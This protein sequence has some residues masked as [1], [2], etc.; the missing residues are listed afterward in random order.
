M[1]IK[2][3][4]SLRAALLSCYAVTATLTTSLTTGTLAIGAVSFTL[5]S[6]QKV[7]AADTIRAKNGADGGQIVPDSNTNAAQNGWTLTQT[8]S[9]TFDFTAGWFGGG[10]FTLTAPTLYVQNWKQTG[11]SGSGHYIVNGNLTN[12]T[13]GAVGNIT[14]AH[15]G[16][17][18]NNAIFNGHHKNFSGNF[19]M[20]IT[21]NGIDFVFTNTDASP[22]DAENPSDGKAISGTGAIELGI[23]DASSAF[24][25]NAVARD[26]IFFYSGDVSIS[27]TAINADALS[28]NG[29]ST[30]ANTSSDYKTSRTAGTATNGATYT[31]SSAINVNTLEINDGST[32]R[33]IERSSSAGVVSFTSGSSLR[34][35]TDATLNLTGASTLTENALLQIEAEGSLSLAAGGS[36][37]INGRLNSITALENAGTVNFGTGA[38]IDITGLTAISTVG[39]TLTYQIINGG[40]LTGFRDLTFANIAGIE[41]ITASSHE[42]LFNDDGSLSITQLL[43]GLSYAGSDDIAAPSPFDWNTTDTSFNGGASAFAPGASVTFTGHSSATLTEAI[44]AGIITIATD[45]SL[46][47]SSGGVNTNTLTAEDIH[48]SGSLTLADADVLHEDTNLVFSA[49]GKVVLADGVSIDGANISS[50]ANATIWLESETSATATITGQVTGSTNMRVSGDGTVVLDGTLLAGVSTTTLDAGATLRVNTGSASNDLKSLAGAGT[51]VFAGNDGN[52][53]L[54]LGNF[55]GTVALADGATGLY[56]LANQASGNTYDLIHTG[57][58]AVNVKIYGTGGP[59]HDTNQHHI[60]NLSGNINFSSGSAAGSYARDTIVLSMTQDN[61]WTGTWAVASTEDGGLRVGSEGDRHH[62]LTITH[63]LTTTAPNE[64]WQALEIRNA[65]VAFAEGGS[66]HTNILFANASSELR[67][68]G[69]SQT[70]TNYGTGGENTAEYISASY[71]TNNEATHTYNEFGSIVVDTGADDK[72]ITVSRENLLYRGSVHV[73][74]GTLDIT[75]AT[76]FVNA[77]AMSIAGG[78]LDLSDLAIA[79]DI[80]ASGGTLMGLASYTGQLSVTGDV[81]VQGLYR[82]KATIANSGSLTLLG[83]WDFD[84]T[85]TN[86]GG[87]IL[88][89]DMTLDLSDAV[90]DASS[91]VQLVSDVNLLDASAW[92]DGTGELDMDKVIGLNLEG[93]TYSYEDGVIKYTLTGTTHDVMGGDAANPLTLQLATGA[94][95][96]GDVMEEGDNITFNDRVNLEMTGDSRSILVTLAEGSIVNAIDTEFALTAENLVL[97]AGSS[98]SARDSI[99]AQSVSMATGSEMSIDSVTDTLFSMT[100]TAYLLINDALAAGAV[101]LDNIS[102]EADSELTLKLAAE[103]TTLSLANFVGVVNVTEGVLMNDFLAYSAYNGVSLAA[104]TGLTITSTLATGAVDM[105]NVT[106]EGK[107]TISAIG[108]VTEAGGGSAERTALSLSD[109]FTGELHL[110]S[111]LLDA[112][113]MNLGASS[114]VF[115]SESGFIATV[116]NT[117]SVVDKDVTIS[118]TALVTRAFTDANLQLTG[119]ITGA[120]DTSIR[121]TDN[122]TATL[123]GDMTDFF[124]A[125]SVQQGKLV[126]DTDALTVDRVNVWAGE[127]LEITAGHQLTTVGVSG[128]MDYYTLNIYHSYDLILGDGA[129]FTDN[130]YMRQGTSTVNIMGTDAGGGTYIFKGYIGADAA[131]LQSEFN[132]GANTSVYI[133]GNV[134]SADDGDLPSFMISHWGQNGATGTFNVSGLLDI[135][136]GISNKDG[137]GYMNV[138]SGGTLVLGQGLYALDSG[139]NAGA[140]NLTVKDGG[141]VKLHNQATNTAA[142]VFVVDFAGGS[143]IEALDATTN[144]TNAIRLSGTGA[145]TL[146]ADAAVTQ[147]NVSSVISEVEGSTSTLNISALAGQSFTLSAA[148]T[149]TTGINVTG[150]GSLSVGNAAALGTGALSFDGAI[151]DLN[152]LAVGNAITANGGTLSNFAK[153]TG[154]LSIAG[155]VDTEGT[156]SGSVTVQT[157][158]SLTLNSIFKPVDTIENVGTLTLGADLLLDLSDI[159]LQPGVELQL[160]KAVGFASSANI[161]AFAPGGVVKDG[162]I[163][164]AVSIGRDYT[165]TTDGKLSYTL[166]GN[167]HTSTTATLDWAD[168]AAIGAGTFANEDSVIFST[169]NA[170]A[171]LEGNVLA[172]QVTVET[173][174]SLTVESADPTYTLDMGEIFLQEN[175]NMIVN[176][177]IDFSVTIANLAAGSSLS[178]AELGLAKVTLT[179]D[180]ALILTGAL[181]AGEHTLEKI[182]GGDTSSLSL[183]SAATGGESVSYL[184]QNFTGNLTLTD[185][186]FSSNLAQHESYASVH[187]LATSRYELTDTLGAA[188]AIN[189]LSADAGGLLTLNLSAAADAGTTL[190]LD[191]TFLGDLEVKS[192]VLSAFSTILNV[193]QVTFNDGTS[194]VFNHSTNEHTF[195][196]DVVLADGANVSIRTWG[197][198]TETELRQVD[199]AVIGEANTT[200]TKTDAGLTQLN[201]IENFKGSIVL[202]NGVGGAGKL[203]INSNATALSNITLEASTLLDITGA[204]NIVNTASYSGGSTTQVDAGASLVVTGADA[205]ATEG[206]AASFHLVGTVNVEGIL[207]VNSAISN[208]AAA[209]TINVEDGGTLVLHEGLYT[210]YNANAS[211]INAKS[212]SSVELGH[213]VTASTQASGA[214][215]HLIANFESGSTITAIDVTT[216]ILNN[217]NITGAGVVTLTAD[218]VVM[219]V[220]VEGIISG[221][222]ALEISGAAGQEFSLNAAN[223]YTGLTSVAGGATLVVGHANALS[224][225]SGLDVVNGSADFSQ[226]AGIS[227]NGILSLNADSTLIMNQVNGGVAL[228]GLSLT[229]NEKSLIDFNTPVAAEFDVLL[230]EGLTADGSITGITFDVEGKADAGDYFTGLA[231]ELTYDKL[232]GTLRYNNYDLDNIIWKGGAGNFSDADGWETKEGVLAPLAELPEADKSITFETTDPTALP[233]S[234][235]VD[236]SYSVVNMTVTGAGADYTFNVADMSDALVIQEKLVVDAGASATFSF[237]PVLGDGIGILVGTGSSLTLNAGGEISIESFTNDGTFTALSYNLTLESATESDGDISV[238]SLALAEG[239]NSFKSVTAAAMVYLG[240]NGTLELSAA[241]SMAGGFYGGGSLNILG[242]TSLLT[243]GTDATALAGNTVLEAD[244][245]TTEAGLTVKGNVVIS[246]PDV[247]EA[248]KVLDVAGALSVTGNIQVDSLIAR[249]SVNVTGTAVLDEM[250]SYGAVTFEAGAQITDSLIST[251]TVTFKAVSSVGTLDNAEVVTFEAIGNNTIGTLVNS[252]SLTSL[253]NLEITDVTKGGNLTVGRLADG[254]I[255]AVTSD[256]T[257]TGDASFDKLIVTGDISSMDNT[258]SLG[259]DSQVLGDI[260]ASSVTLREGSASIGGVNSQ[261]M[262]SG[263]ALSNAGT[264]TLSLGADAIVDAF[265]NTGTV[266]IDGGLTVAKAVTTG[267]ILTATGDV[268]LSGTSSF[269][270]INTDAAIRQALEEVDL[271]VTANSKAASIATGAALTVANKDATFTLTDTTAPTILSSFSGAGSLDT[272]STQFLQLDNAS[273]GNSISMDANRLILGGAL[274]LSGSLTTAAGTL[275]LNMGFDA[276]AGPVLTAQSVA[277]ATGLELGISFTQLNDL[278]LS[279]EGSYTLTDVEAGFLSSYDL[280]FADTTNATWQVDN[281]TYTLGVDADTLAGETHGQITITLTITG[282]TWQSVDGNWDDRADNWSGNVPQAGDTAYFLG[283]GTLGVVVDGDKEVGE[284]RVQGAY[285]FSGDNIV[286]DSLT[287]TDSVNTLDPTM[288]VTTVSNQI[289]VNGLTSISNADTVLHLTTQEVAPGVMQSGVLHTEYL[290]ITAGAKLK[291]D[292]GSTL[293]VG[294]NAADAPYVNDISGTI[295]N[296]GQVALF[297]KPQGLEYNIATLTGS[298]GELEIHDGADVEVGTLEQVSVTLAAGASLDLTGASDIGVLLGDG[299][300]VLAT[301]L[302][303]SGEGSDSAAH[304]V[305]NE[306]TIDLKDHSLGTLNVDTLI[307][308]ADLVDGADALLTVSSIEGATAG[309]AFSLSFAD[310]FLNLGEGSYSLLSS[311]STLSWGE[312]TMDNESLLEIQELVKSGL[313]ISYTE[314][315]GTLGFT[316]S[317]ATNRIWTVSNDFAV[318][319][320]LDESSQNAIKPM[321]ED[322]TLTANSGELVNY[323]VL[324]SVDTVIVD[325]NF[326][327]DLSTQPADINGAVLRDTMGTATLT[328]VGGKATLENSGQSLLHGLTLDDTE[329]D[330]HRDG[331]AGSLSIN[332]LSA[333]DANIDV[334]EGGRLTVTDAMLT[335]STISVGDGVNY[336]GYASSLTV[337]NLT[338]NGTSSVTVLATTS[339]NRALTNAVALTVKE[340]LTL[341]DD[342]SHIVDTGAAEQVKALDANGNSEFVVKDGGQA[343]FGSVDLADNA[344]LSATGTGYIEI[345]EITASEETNSIEGHIIVGNGTYNGA[346]SNATTFETKA[347]GTTS[348]TTGRMLSVVGGVGSHITLVDR[349]NDNSVASLNTTGS[350]V[351]VEKNGLLVNGGTMTDSTLVFKVDA[352]GIVDQMKNGT[353]IDLLDNNS[354]LTLSGTQI[355][356]GQTDDTVTKLDFTGIDTSGNYTLFDVNASGLEASDISFAGTALSKYFSGASL[357]GDELILNFNQEAYLSKA[358]SANG[359]AGA[360]LVSPLIFATQ[361]GDLKDVLDSMDALSGSAADSLAA[362]VAG[363]SVTSLGSSMLSS[364]ERQ[365]QNVRN[366]TMSMGGN[367]MADTLGPVTSAWISAEGSFSKLEEDGTA[368]GHDYSTFGGSFGVDV[369]VDSQV[370]LGAVFTS[371]YGTV[372]SSGADSTTGDLNTYNV[373][374]FA[375]VTHGQWSHSFVA[376]AGLADASLERTVTHASGSYTSEGDT[377]GFGLGLMYEVGY[378]YA[379][380]EEAGM[381]LQP[382]FNVSLVHA[383]ISGYSEEGSNASLEVGDQENSYATFGIGA[384]FESIVGESAFNRNAVFSS[385]AMLKFD[386]G[387]RNTDAQVNLIGQSTSGTVKG[388]E[389]GN[390]GLELGAGLHIPVGPESGTLFMDAGVEVREQQSDVNAS[391]GYRLSF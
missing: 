263:I 354:Q 99:E 233:A 240:K 77:S 288:S 182:Y 308:N 192:G 198:I 353:T 116:A 23:R 363:A 193:G 69:E 132:V 87:V 54:S 170:V 13:T 343:Y 355:I 297:G 260:T 70:V 96:A 277:G 75:M 147:V 108:N 330:V 126:L 84:S 340:K 107:L 166:T 290:S 18:Y 35:G 123:S 298:T 219:N 387:E 209:G 3:N 211:T 134:T 73:E 37:T 133:T 196:P 228:G 376:T 235:V 112:T 305:A 169:T 201:N 21:G 141:T 187:L 163:I 332:E 368:A 63:G 43:D 94:P 379:V 245:L 186:A 118:A 139:S 202:E 293:Y 5:L 357:N 306:L 124:G 93:R 179:D 32:A 145:V 78:V 34:I 9:I 265:H 291:L 156:L 60:G 27:N 29:E 20:A 282:N 311:T 370:T 131:G 212:G 85:L 324:D 135:T 362:A 138:E 222:A 154:D 328:L 229:A 181:A 319:D 4:R 52:T 300:D 71:S 312:L 321:F 53:R 244:G 326:T 261:G 322:G 351:M 150:A 46:I 325:R 246:N 378:S 204:G 199:G 386:A 215:A 16:D 210:V 64:N 360:K 67:Y 62:T 284:L 327:L 276:K 237:P 270:S 172:A 65:T 127:E 171:T 296:D 377:D 25:A 109:L 347:Y 110:N 389:A 274:T 333:E 76:A 88:G 208:Q 175:A 334:S 1:K 294:L 295:E 206:E 36:L 103:G 91:S 157:G 72:V 262:T 359:A 384:R 253:G 268:A 315:G 83:T 111:G 100:G 105:S 82:P 194:L 22:E 283:A 352:A 137:I 121:K 188:Q 225:S 220:N 176:K 285:N 180:A 346:Y 338:L 241:S 316:L 59:G 329:L 335:D 58:E 302:T 39:D 275:S 200:L 104:D 217:T 269:T 74:S 320:G 7:Q 47:L 101:N 382:V 381:I 203:I 189:D 190:T 41:G 26:A 281:R 130:F 224:T 51:L 61:T 24:G 252:S 238:Q 114:G 92:L 383:S 162:N 254:A 279:H 234:V 380:D 8:D 323:R 48:L 155:I 80:S 218:V 350:T 273:S 151:L 342:S 239:D 10:T 243:L 307:L 113:A 339:T 286:A 247:T 184:T 19:V 128:E 45:S 388:A 55:T 213:Q 256:L 89:A 304:I 369:A 336:S 142:G 231:G 248:L 14:F 287:H 364:V 292:A 348:L 15:S 49:E 299:G 251:G 207:S 160:F 125:F 214:E 344:A 98:L 6:A 272:A 365:L 167:T 314:D 95:I 143:T 250:E 79:N 310:Q 349:M 375:R 38:L 149:F 17:A 367:M 317:E 303:I 102:S 106:G 318:S 146:S 115:V 309:S 278:G 221:T 197:L 264:G 90:F 366:R 266:D 81:T 66:W 11:G 148:N 168:G 40:T 313:D 158:A 33:L 185:G 331:V 129:V 390:V 289:Q 161:D 31:I 341:N 385:R 257:L 337:N 165:L 30:G 2:L 361:T 86:A 242:T 226:V 57:T 28:L 223:T 144:I 258:L 205:S 117:T 230:F 191:D 68:T 391:V 195:T 50:L 356:I 159:Q 152:D 44:T 267:G 232:A 97:L 216:D 301:E 120:V 255:T 12:P 42:V 371:L 249:G 178:M 164:G 236:G 373:S 358:S 153:Y 140:V 177:D 280:S 56:L 374:A 183:A 119:S 259:A 173:G 122:G 345:D 372:S 227:I 174:L 136:S 271:T